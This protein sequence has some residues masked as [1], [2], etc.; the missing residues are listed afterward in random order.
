MTELDLLIQTRRDLHRHPELAFEEHRTAGIVAERLSAAGYEVRAGVAGTGV[1]GTMRGGA[2]A[3]ATL[4]LRADMDALPVQE[5]TKH[6]FP[7][8]VSGKMHA[9]G[10]D[11]HVAIGL[12]VA[13]RLAKQRAAWAG[14]IRYCFQPAEEGAGGAQRMIAE[15]TLDG[16]DAAMGLHVW[17][18]LPS[19]VVGV[20]DGPQMAGAREFRI[21]VH[22]R[23]GHGAIPQETIDATLV[24]SQIVVALQ[25]IVSRNVSPLDTAVVT[26]GSF[27]AGTAQ[28]IIAATAVLE[29]TLRAYR[30]EL[31]AE[32]QD[33]VKRVA[34]GIATALGARAEITFG[35]IIFPPTVNAPEMAGLVRG[36]VSELLG[37]ER[38]AAADEVRTMGAEDFAEFSSRVPGCFFF[39]GARDPS[40]GA[41]FPHHSPHFDISEECLPI[42]VEV[43][44]QAALGYLGERRVG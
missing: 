42:G 5:D 26:V 16:V 14:E 36:A 30:M 44:E 32:L 8:T 22:G 29:G 12:A 6:D 9:C 31:L 18:G 43:M 20:V 10:H 40:I 15:G 11:A 23:G 27:H 28:N 25:S 21:V 37:E 41:D 33:H 34:E 13:E 1:I 4:L 24:A 2:G 19:G 7:S 38:L 3:G 39:V 35:E 17:S